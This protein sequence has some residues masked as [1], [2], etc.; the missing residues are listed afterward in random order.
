MK[1]ERKEGKQKSTTAQKSMAPKVWKIVAIGV[2]AIF[3]LFIVVGLIKEHYIRSSF[4]RP[5]QAQID[6]ATRIARDRLQSS[7]K[8]VSS[9]HI[10]VGERMPRPPN[11]KNARTLLQVLFYNDTT[12]HAYLVDISSGEVIMHSETEIY[13]DFWKQDKKRQDEKAWF[14]WGPRPGFFPCENDVKAK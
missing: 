1:S 7:G 12:T 14:P 6:Y 11:D 3:V 13:K 9:F 8:D 2:I 5:T 4:V 10:E